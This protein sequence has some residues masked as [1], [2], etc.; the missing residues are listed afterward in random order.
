[1]ASTAQLELLSIVLNRS[2]E[3][4]GVPEDELRAVGTER[5]DRDISEL[6]AEGLVRTI[7]GG[8]G[9]PDSI[10]IT[11]AGRDALTAPPE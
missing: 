1:M 5:F 7:G 6:V 9:E 10:A 3:G 8:D 4:L 2:P 11:D